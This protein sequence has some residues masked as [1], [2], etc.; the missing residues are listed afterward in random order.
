MSC[1]RWGRAGGWWED[2]FLFLYGGINMKCH[3]CGG[4]M[5]F[6]RFYG[7]SDQFSGWRCILCG[8]IVDPVIFENR[9]SQKR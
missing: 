2:F 4:A 6:E 1:S 8:E 9:L 7:T 5:V 3:R